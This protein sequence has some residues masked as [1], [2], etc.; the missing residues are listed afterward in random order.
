MLSRPDDAAHQLALREL[1]VE[2][3]TDIVG[4]VKAFETDHAEI[5]VD[6]HFGE[7][8][9]ERMQCVLFL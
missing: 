8:R 6:A 3:P 9:A 5:G 7:R 1:G 2:P 4:A